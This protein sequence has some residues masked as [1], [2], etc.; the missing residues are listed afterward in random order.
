[1]TCV[2]K[3]PPFLVSLVF[4]VSTDV[5][6]MLTNSDYYHTHHIQVFK[7]RTYAIASSI[8][9][10]RSIGTQENAVSPVFVGLLLAG[11]FKKF[12][13]DFP[14]S[15][16]THCCYGKNFAFLRLMLLKLAEMAAATIIDFPLNI[17][18]KHSRKV[19]WAILSTKWQLAACRQ[20]YVTSDC[21]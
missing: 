20:W 2:V 19:A 6:F 14:E 15:I 5:V 7:I 4:P 1:L 13:S 3:F 9:D 10:I 17:C 12:S 16:I 11:L 8:S 21:L 18:R